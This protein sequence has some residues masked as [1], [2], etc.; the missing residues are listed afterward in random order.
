MSLVLNGNGT[1]QNLVAGGLPDGSVTADD[2]ASLPAGSVLQVVHQEGN[3]ST[4]VS[5]GTGYCGWTASITLSSASNKI[6]V[7]AQIPI[8]TSRTN[9]GDPYLLDTKIYHQTG[10]LT[11]TGSGASLAFSGNTTSTVLSDLYP[12]RLSFNSSVSK[13][14]NTTIHCNKLFSTTNVL[15]H[16]TFSSRINADM[17]DLIWNNQ[18]E[19][20]SLY[21]ITLM[22]IAG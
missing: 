21:Q 7:L 15:N 16:F 11:T 2:I 22:E 13:E 18:F 5:D 10:T 9:G 14:L 19:D 12:N 17:I 4:T 20:G 3:T 1:I 6:L 8:F